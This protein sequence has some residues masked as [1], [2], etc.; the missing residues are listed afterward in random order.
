M[1]RRRCLQVRFDGFTGELD[2]MNQQVNITKAGQAREE[3]P[4]TKAFPLDGELADFIASVR[5]KT[6]PAVDGAAA[7]EALTLVKQAGDMLAAI[8]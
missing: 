6:K 1:S 7:L 4:V 2:Y 3:I 5:H 8:G